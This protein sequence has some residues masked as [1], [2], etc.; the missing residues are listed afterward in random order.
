MIRVPPFRSAL[1]L[2]A[3]VTLTVVAFQQTAMIPVGPAATA[4]THSRNA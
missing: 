4:A 1:A 2:V 3:S